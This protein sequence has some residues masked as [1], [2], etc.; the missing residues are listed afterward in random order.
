MTQVPVPPPVAGREAWIDVAKG[1]AITLVVLYHAIMY[2]DEVGLAG[3]LAP[4][5][6]LFDTFRMPLFFFMS[7]ILAASAI[8]LPYWQLFRKRMSLLLYLYLAWVTLQT[9]FLLALPPISPSGAP[10]TTWAS[11]VTLFIRP[12]S[13]LWFIYALPLFFTLAWLMRR[14]SPL[15]Q[16]ALATVIAVLFGA[17]LLHT[18][19]PWDKMGKY[20]VF[21]IAAIYLGPLVRRLVPRVRW[22]HVVLLCLGYAALVV[23]TTKLN[24]TKVPFVLLVVSTL[25]VVV[26]ISV[27]VLLAKIPAFDF[28][29]SLGSRTLPIYL[30]HTFPMTALAAILVAFDVQAPVAVATLLPPLLCT[31][32][33]LLALA[34]HRRFQA[35]PGVFSVPVAS[36]VIAP[37]RTAIPRGRKVNLT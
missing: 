2:L 19:S 21:F 17:Q 11:L 8:R 1:I 32:A 30:V 25:A 9:L 26:G 12:S 14:W 18:G 4:L 6:P 34:L 31:G 28:V 20:L 15:L 3:A 16:V 22:W 7:G 36:W 23:V 35:V 27:A 33:I 24:V 13:N 37:K 10:N 5:N 29:R